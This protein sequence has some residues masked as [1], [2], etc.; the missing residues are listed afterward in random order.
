MSAAEPGKTMPI[1]D[2]VARMNAQQVD[3][4]FC[5]RTVDDIKEVLKLARKHGKAVSMRG[6]RHSMGGHTIAA[7]GYVIDLMRLNSW[8]FDP[9]AETVTTGPGAMWADLIVGLN[10][11]GYSPRTM[12]SYSTFSVGGS[13]AV[14]AHGITTDH[15]MA[16]GVV[17]FTLIRW[18]GSEVV[19][20]REAP[21]AAGELF[22]LA[23]G[24]Y[25]VNDREART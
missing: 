22:G 8:S 15:C 9:S 25:G 1:V 5:V 11:W 3:R 7:R 4:L 23:L 17:N 20:S 10:E 24:G 16:E 13:L 6:T 2:D 18:D 12:Q 19:C 21:G 14:N